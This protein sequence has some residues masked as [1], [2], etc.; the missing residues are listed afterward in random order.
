[1]TGQ[2]SFDKLPDM[3]NTLIILSLLALSGCSFERGESEYTFNQCVRQDLFKQCMTNVPKGP[4][5]LTGAGNDWDE[6]ISECNAS[7]R[8]MAWRKRVTIPIECQGQL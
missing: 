7:A 5:R 1:M 8:Q 6:V 3:K 2:K 4:E